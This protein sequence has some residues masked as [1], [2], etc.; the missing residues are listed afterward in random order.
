MSEGVYR[1]VL[2]VCG[3]LLIVFSAYFIYSGVGFALA[4]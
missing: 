3:A 2:L 1:G 4:A